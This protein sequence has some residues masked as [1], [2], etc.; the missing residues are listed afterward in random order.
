[1]SL[2]L[3]SPPYL[4]FGNVGYN[5]KFGSCFVLEDDPASRMF[6][7]VIGV[8][9]CFVPTF[10]I[11]IYC[12]FR[13]TMTFIRSRE[14]VKPAITTN[15]P[16]AVASTSAKP[17]TIATVLRLPGIYD[18][19]TKPRPK[20]TTADGIGLEVKSERTSK[21]YG[22][23]KRS[24]LPVAGRIYPVNRASM[25]VLKRVLAVWAVFVVC[26]VPFTVLVILN[27]HERVT[28]LT[29]HVAFVFSQSNSAL[30]PVVYFGI[31]REFRHASRALLQKWRRRI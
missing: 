16:V 24:I 29:M 5:R 2:A 17:S 8:G 11:T 4:G 7:Q 18:D 22:D 23:R 10:V 15:P 25:A 6:L 27:R 12:Y 21:L 13:I 31:G 1:M 28:A 19:R 3:G 30:N 9:C 20:E 14:R 26:W